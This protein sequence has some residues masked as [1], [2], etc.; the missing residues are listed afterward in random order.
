MIATDWGHDWGSCAI[1]ELSRQLLL[2]AAVD[3]LI[4]RPSARNTRAI[5]A[6]R[7]AGFAVHDPSLHRLP[8]WVTIVGL[9]YE[10]SVVSVKTRAAQPA[11]EL[12]KEPGSTGS[13]SAHAA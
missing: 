3:A 8:G 13:R 4:I 2:H 10:D 1:R 11:I 6:Y 5:G 9:D 12:E 7:R